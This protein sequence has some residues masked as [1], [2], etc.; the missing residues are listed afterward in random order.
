[1][2]KPPAKIGVS[3]NQ[4]KQSVPIFKHSIILENSYLSVFISKV[5]LFALIVILLCTILIGLEPSIGTK[6]CKALPSAKPKVYIK[7][8]LFQLYLSDFNFLKYKK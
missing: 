3:F 6:T 8:L 4:F 7:E 2:L 1:M 5:P